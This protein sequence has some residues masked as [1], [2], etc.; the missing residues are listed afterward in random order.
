MPTNSTL[1]AERH[2]AGALPAGER[3]AAIVAAALPLM[4][5]RGT[6]VT[7]KQIAD[8]AGVAEGTLF[9]V[10][11]DKNALLRAVI[12]AALDTSRTAA[13]IVAIDRSLPIERRLED[14]VR[15]VQRRTVE[16]WRVVSAAADS[17]A[18][19]G[20]TP[21]R[22]GDLEALA[23]L[24]EPERDRLRYEPVQA[25][26][27]L[28]ALAVASSHPALHRGD[29]MAPSEIVS[30]VLDGIRSRPSP[31]PPGGAARC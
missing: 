21:T 7:T 16:M 29:P 17:D 30:I 13:A 10:F 1:D 9:R 12:D 8:A 6:H 15:I 25:A 28:R 22:P 11:P 5:E 3:R 2:R 27:A 20:R 14:A 19:K 23:E 24:F 26:L 4:V 18:I 31:L